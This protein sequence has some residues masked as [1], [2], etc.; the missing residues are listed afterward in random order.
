MAL[1]VRYVHLF[2]IEELKNISA[3]PRYFLQ[4]PHDFKRF[5]PEGL[6]SFLIL[7]F[8]RIIAP[9]P[10]W[11]LANANSATPPANAEAPVSP[12]VLGLV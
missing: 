3:D 1:S 5:E 12:T 2:A 9:R 8:I 7:C 11:P 4:L 6:M 10:P